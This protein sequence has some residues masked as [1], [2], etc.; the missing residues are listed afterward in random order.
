MFLFICFKNNSGIVDTLNS[1]I[2]IHLRIFQFNLH[3]LA[4][5]FVLILQ[6]VNML[7]ALRE[8]ILGCC[9]LEIHIYER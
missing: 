2:N 8:V 9:M 6:C 7:Q 1:E 5:K 3:I 4:T